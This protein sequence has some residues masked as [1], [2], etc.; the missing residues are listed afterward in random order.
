MALVWAATPA[1]TKSLDLFG[2]VVGTVTVDTTTKIYGDD[3]LKSNSSAGGAA[4]HVRVVSGLSLSAGRVSVRIIGD[5]PDAETGVLQV[6]SAGVVL[7]FGVSVDNLGRI[8]LRAGALAA[9]SD[10]PST[11]KVTAA[12]L[13]RLT[14]CW[15]IRTTT[16]WDAA[17]YFNDETTAAATL[18]G[19][20]TTLNATTVG[21]VRVGWMTALAA[22]LVIN[23]GHY[24]V[25]NDSSLASWRPGAANLDDRGPRVTS[26]QPGTVNTADAAWTALLT[27]EVNDRPIVSTTGRQLTG[28]TGTG[29]NTYNVIAQ[30]AGDVD[31]T[32]ATL[33]GYLGWMYAQKS[34]NTGTPTDAIVLGGLA[35]T[36]IAVTTTASIFQ[37]AA[38]TSA[39]YPTTIGWNRSVA[40][41][42][43][44]RFLDAGI[45]IVYTPAASFS[46]SGSGGLS[47]GGAATVKAGRTVAGAGGMTFSGVATQTKG[48][49]QPTS[50]GIVF[51]GAGN[52]FGTAGG[53]SFSITGAGGVSFGGAA[54]VAAGRVITG[55][56]GL[57]FAGSVTPL[58][59][60]AVAGAGGLAFGG[61]AS[62]TAGRVQAGAGGVTFSGSAIFAGGRVMTGAGGLT[63]AGAGVLAAG[64]VQPT[65]GGLSFGG[66][67]SV[68]FGRVQTGA[69][70]LVFGG[71]ATIVTEGLG[72]FSITGTGGVAFGGAAALAQGRVQPA[73][74]GFAFGGAASVTCGR[75]VVGAGGLSFSGSTV[76]LVGRSISGTGGLLWGGSAEFA[77]GMAILPTGGI[78]WG[79]SAR[80]RT[81]SPGLIVSLDLFATTGIA[82]ESYAAALSTLN[83]V[84][85]ASRDVN[86]DAS[87]G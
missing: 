1:A 70:G 50:G 76:P 64:R 33:I 74:G 80:F 78:V 37:T 43:D 20:T 32:N 23:H 22:N 24:A 85:S 53:A 47:F 7:T 36:V 56:G 58:Y 61:A 52:P 81:T 82:V 63:F 14:L 87:A 11:A 34:S 40:A 83:L 28:N 16:D 84:A 2:T 54:S 77:L 19:G 59:G 29:V 25:D 35:N 55:S 65:N 17:V 9:L 75:R 30:S 21:I 6:M 73:T 3:T 44:A 49:V 39:S 60:R 72:T 68:T 10:G 57:S 51:S 38:V 27:G 13:Y 8:R 12:T 15:N 66:T 48:R 62:W 86:A 41:S 71:S 5:L 79:G 42:A 46:V 4:A 69:G 18:V 67:A 31:L 26:K 45:V